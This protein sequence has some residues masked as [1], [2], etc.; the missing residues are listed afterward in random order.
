MSQE[1]NATVI[2]NE[3]ISD[4][5]YLLTVKPDFEIK[6]FRPGQ[7]TTLGLKVKND[8]EEK[9]IKRAYSIASS[10]AQHRY[11]E[12]YIVLVPEGMLSRNL[13]DLQTDDRLFVGSKITGNFTLD[14]IPSKQNLL[15]VC[16][17]TGI[18]PFISMIRTD[19]VCGGNNRNF[20]ILHGARHSYDLG[21]F[22]E[23]QVLDLHCNNFHYIPAVSR[24]QNDPYWGGPTGRVTKVIKD[25]L[26]E[27]KSG[28]AITPEN[29]DI[30]L[31]GNPEMIKEMTLHFES[32]GFNSKKGEQRIN[33]HSEKYW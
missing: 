12:F 31:C 18:A 23:L 13:F 3:V 33:I 27:E 8:C 25:G 20:V 26:V 4:G 9:L 7:F 14:K 22:S 19:L 21:F 1:Y 6:N 30:L 10:P 11:L 2:K 5:L 32:L 29:F 16:T 24:H 17:G 28:M 15:M